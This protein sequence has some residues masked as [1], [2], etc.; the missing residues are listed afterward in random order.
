[1]VPMKVRHTCGPRGGAANEARLAESTKT[2]ISR[3]TLQRA[4]ISEA[5]FGFLVTFPILEGS[6]LSSANYHPC[7]IY[8]LINTPGVINSGHGW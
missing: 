6:K 1:M 8:P 5:I 4:P 3:N 7:A 2:S